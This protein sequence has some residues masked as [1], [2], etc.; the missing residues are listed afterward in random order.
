VTLSLTTFELNN[1]DKFQNL[2]FS[3]FAISGSHVGVY[4]DDILLGYA[5]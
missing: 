3:S 5:M 2:F 4:E 1:K